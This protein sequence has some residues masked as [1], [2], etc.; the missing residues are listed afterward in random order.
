MAPSCRRRI[1]SV[2][3]CVTVGPHTSRLPQW[4]LI[5]FTNDKPLFARVNGRH[6]QAET[7]RIINL[8]S[9]FSYNLTDL[10]TETTAIWFAV[11]W[12]KCGSGE[13]HSTMGS[14]QY[15]LPA[16][17]LMSCN[18]ASDSAWSMLWQWLVTYGGGIVG[19]GCLKIN[20]I[21]FH[22]EL[23]QTFWPLAALAVFS[24]DD[25]IQHLVSGWPGPCLFFAHTLYP[26]N[27]SAL[28]YS[29]VSHCSLGWLSN[30]PTGT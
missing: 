16:D 3:W 6:K 22:E 21:I 10:E 11:K 20:N 8:L 5:C 4:V 14:I 7:C 26:T 23:V 12:G 19:L 27:L 30:L 18:Q 9:S 29:T 2:T 15:T 13:S 24:P 1:A 25:F 28:C 17:R